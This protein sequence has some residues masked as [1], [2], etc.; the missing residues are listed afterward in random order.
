[1]DKKFTDM[2]IPEKIGTIIAWIIII[3]LTGSIVVA[4]ISKELTFLGII[5]W[6]MS[7]FGWYL[8][9][10]IVAPIIL[11]LLVL[12]F[13]HALPYIMVIFAMLGLYL[14]FSNVSVTVG[15]ICLVVAAIV[16]WVI[17]T[18]F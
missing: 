14:L 16:L 9:A 11:G 3:A 12:L 13:I 6:I 18:L 7:A 15:I 1:M 10:L 5:S 17:T 8:V 4:I 2:T